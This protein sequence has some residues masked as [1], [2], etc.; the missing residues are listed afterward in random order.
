[1]V[2]SRA[3]WTRASDL[4]SNAL[5]ASS[6]SKMA[7]FFRIARAMA[8]LCFCPPDNCTPLSPHIDLQ[9]QSFK[10]HLCWSGQVFVCDIALV[11]KLSSVPVQDGDINKLTMM[12]SCNDI[13]TKASFQ[14]NI[15]LKITAETE[16]EIAW[17]KNANLSATSCTMT[18]Y[19]PPVFRIS[20]SCDPD[21]VTSPD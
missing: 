20:W 9:A 13:A 17:A 8:I 6:R 11:K 18:E 5:V 3:S 19:G 15:I 14:D 2:F 10:G 4:R 21:S 16:A 1:M 12:T 7:G